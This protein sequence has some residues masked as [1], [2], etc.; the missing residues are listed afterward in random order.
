MVDQ[1]ELIMQ[2]QRVVLT[3]IA[4]LS[5]GKHLCPCCGCYVQASTLLE[6][7]EED[8]SLVALYYILFP[9]KNDGHS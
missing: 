2:A 8:C 4:T 6:A 9:K 7:H 5:T 3:T 1:H